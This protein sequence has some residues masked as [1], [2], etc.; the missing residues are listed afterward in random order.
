MQNAQTTWVMVIGLFTIL[1]VNAACTDKQPDTHTTVEP[2][3]IPADRLREIE[4]LIAQGQKTQPQILEQI[5]Q[6][7]A[8]LDDLRQTPQAQRLAQQN[9]LLFPQ[10]NL[11]ALV[12]AF[13]AEANYYQREMG[14]LQGYFTR[15]H[16]SDCLQRLANAQR[17][18]Q[19]HC[20]QPLQRLAQADVS[21]HAGRRAADAWVSAYN[22]CKFD[23]GTVGGYG[24]VIE[25]F[26][27]GSLECGKLEPES[28]ETIP[29]SSADNF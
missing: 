26:V 27:T 29:N 28:P 17:Y 11:Q 3:D 16:A 7:L 15:H 9:D 22:F 12:A 2:S 19:S 8:A 25:N 5:E 13:S 4:A 18:W 20:Q 14:E 23:F 10:T 6:A 1:L 21:T 24:V